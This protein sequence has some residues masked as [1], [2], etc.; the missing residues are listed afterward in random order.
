VSDWNE[1]FCERCG[2]A[3]FVHVV[4]AED[5]ADGLGAA[6]WSNRC[7]D[8]GH[9]GEYLPTPAEIRREC[10]LIR[11]EHGLPVDEEACDPPRAA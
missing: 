4:H 7:R 10:L 2:S 9:E 11:H 3:D 1:I 5:A 6:R 8:C